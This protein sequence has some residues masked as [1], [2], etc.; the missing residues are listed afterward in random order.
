MARP[1]A[2][3]DPEFAQRVA[4]MLADGLSRREIANRLGVKDPMTISRWRKDP[5]VTGI[6]TGLINDRVREVT[7]KVDS[8]I[9][10]I[11]EKDDLTIQELLAIRKEFLGGA[12]RAEAEKADH[13]TV[14]EAM[15]AAE[16]PQFQQ[17]LAELFSSAPSKE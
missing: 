11:L 2:L 7:R 12:L 5:R 1:N 15:T 8:K 10:G 3:A 16:D 14:N 4:E 13:V 17:K 9:A 6:L